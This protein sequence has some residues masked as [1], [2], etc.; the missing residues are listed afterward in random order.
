MRSTIK[1]ILVLAGALAAV[2]VLPAAALDAGADQ[3]GPGW[4][5]AENMPENG[6]GELDGEN[7][8]DT[9][10]AG[11]TG[12]N[13]SES[14]DSAAGKAQ[15]DERYPAWLT[16]DVKD[17]VVVRADSESSSYA[18]V[19][20]YENDGAWKEVFSVRG[21]L[22]KSGLASRE[23]KREG[24]KKTPAGVYSFNK[25]FGIK[26]DPGSVMEYHRVQ[27]GDVWVDDSSSRQY[28]RMVNAAEIVKDWN[29]AEN[30]IT[31][32]PWYNYCLS[33]NYNEEQTPGKGS[34]IFLHCMKE[35]DWGTSGCVGIPEENMKLLLQS[36]DTHGKIVIVSE[37]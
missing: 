10:N 14:A 37:K 32:G 3:S 8:G 33:L 22:G 9:G 15:R 5:M 18:T 31:M 13:L 34:A 21:V 24:D 19:S 36:V 20:Y 7:V 28:N 6:N 16:A 29:S 23:E 35:G 30:L 4:E 12:A 26:E 2:C 1:R 11:K 25:S 17:V 27:K